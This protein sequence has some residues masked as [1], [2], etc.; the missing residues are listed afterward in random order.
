MTT[1]P[2]GA[3]PGDYRAGLL[4]ALRT[5]EQLRGR[6]EELDSGAHAPAEPIAVVGLSCRLPGGAQ[7]PESYWRMLSEGV[8]G[9]GE[10]PAERGDARALYDPDP[11]A[12][13]K[14]YT[15]RGAFLGR[16]DRFEPAVFG[17]SPREALG[18][19][20]QHRLA[21]EVAWEALERAGYAPDSLDGSNTGVYLGVSTTDYVRLRQAHGAAEDVDAY[22]LV[23]EPSFTAGRISYTLGLRGP[24][25]V[26]DTTCS[27]SLVAVHEACQAL[28]L[29]ECDMAL[30]GGVN[31][32]LA[33]YGFVL[34]SKFR[35][36][37]PDG[38]C[39][40]FDAAADGYARGEGAGVVTLKRLSDA[41]RDGDHISAVI[42]GSAVGHDGRSS[43]LTV[44]NPAAQQQV[45]NGALAQAHIAP[46]DVDYVEAHG[47]GTALGDP[48]ELR[49][50]QAA[51]A[52]HRPGGEPLL[53]GS[54]KTNI[55]H[56]ESAAGVAGL[57]KLI[58]ALEHRHI[59]PHLHF[60]T[61]N[62][63]VDWNRLRIRV[64]AEGQEWPERGRE[65]IGAI[66]SFGA[67]GTNAHAVLGSAPPPPADAAVRERGHRPYGLLLASARTPEA[68]RESAERHARALR[69][70]Q[71]SALG[72]VCW[73]TQVGRARQQY[74]LA[75]VGD[76]LDSL[77]EALE[78]YV[79]G[80]DDRRLA[81]TALP[82]HKHRKTAWLF[83]GQGA[84]YPGMCRDLLGE[85][86]FRAAFEE[87]ERIIDPLLGRPLRQVLWPEQ[88]GADRPIDD[89]RYT[90]PA[91]FAV[92]Y[93]LAR[94][95]MAWGLRPG[96]LLGHS[97]GEIAAACVAG[98]FGLADACR[99]VVARAALM[100]GLPAGGA[101]AAV[102]CS[103]A[104]ARAAIADRTDL[105]A[106]AAVNGPEET[107]LSGDADE[108]ASVLEL[109]AAGG[110]RGRRLPVSHAFHSPLLE[111]M[112]KAF[113]EVAEEIDYAAPTLPLIS[114]VTG[115][116]WGPEEIGPDYW[117][118][119]AASPVRFHDGL[120]AL[121]AQGHRTFLE[122]GPAPVL[123]GIG[124]RAID[125]AD[126]A[127]I[128]SLLPPASG[129][130]GRATVRR[131]LGLLRLRGAQPDWAAVHDGE[132]LRR[133]PLPTTPWRGESYWFGE[134]RPAAVAVQASPGRDVPGVGRRLNTAVPTYELDLGS[135]RW[136][137][138]ARTDEDGN[139]YIPL[140][141]M[142]GLTVAAA[143][144]AL[145][146]SW[147][148]VEE[149]DLLERLPLAREPQTL[150]ITVAATEDG[151][152][153]FAYRGLSRTEEE[154]GAPWRLHVRGVLRHHPAPAAGRPA[155]LGDL[156][157]GGYA[158]GFAYEP[159]VLSEAL[160]GAVT[161]AHRGAGGVLV[162]LDPVRGGDGTA[163]VGVM[164]AAVAALSWDAD[165]DRPGA[166]VAGFA[167]HVGLLIC[168]DPALVRYVRATAR[169]R[170]GLDGLPGEETVGAAEF[171]AEDG[172]HIGGV[173]ELRVL[174]AAATARRAAPWRRPDELLSR[175][176]W[177]PLALPSAPQ[178]T[179]SLRG[180]D[181]PAS[182]AG[183]SWLLLPDRG[184]VATRLAAE[185]RARGAHCS[186]ADGVGAEP[187]SVRALLARW[188]GQAPEEASL[189]V[190]VCTGLDAPSNEEADLDAIEEYRGRSELTAVVV[191][192]ELLASARPGQR[193]PVS[194]VTRGAQAAGPAAVVEPFGA[195]LWGLGR[196]LALEHPEFWGG[197]VDLG[198]ALGGDDESPWLLAALTDP[199]EDQQALRGAERYVAR[200]V[201]HELSADEQRARP[202]L[203][204]DAT[205]LVT[206][207]FGGIGQVLCRWLAAG[208]AG[209][210][211]L[212]GR[213]AL[214]D[215]ADWDEPALSPEVRARL[216]LVRDLEAMGVEVEIVVADVAD[217][218]TMRRVVEELTH[219]DRARRPLRGVVHAAGTSVPQFL[220]DIP[221]GDPR[222]YD[223]VWR[224]KVIGG[225]LLHQLTDGLELD[226]F[227]NFSSI[228]A[229]WGSQH[230][231]SY[232]AANAFLDAL[233]EHRHARGLPA[234]SVS[235]GPWDLASNLFDDD[236]LAFLTATG[237]R[238]LS[239]PQCL[240]LLGAL[241]A[242]K[243]PQAVVCAA[244]WG[245]YKPVMEARGER[246]L[247]RTVE[248]PEEESGPQ[249]SPL[250]DHL[251]SAAGA[252]ERQ[253]LLVPY[254][255]E[256]LG[257]V[258]GVAQDSLGPESD[259]LANGLDSLMV[260][261]VVKRCRRDL[262]VT[263][264]PNQ[265]FER[266]TL[267][268]WAGLLAD[269]T[270][271]STSADSGA[272]AID[273]T[274][275]SAWAD[276]ARIAE[277]VTLDPAIRPGSPP[278]S[279]YTEPRE[280][281]LTG[282]TGF[283]GAYLLDELLATT[284]A[285]VHCLVRCADAEQG[286]SRIRANYERY[287]P[288]RAE[289]A[290]RVAVVPGDL[291]L[292]LLGMDEAGFD[293]LADRL[294]AIYHNGALV[295]FSHTYEQ[296]RPANVAGTEEILR[297][298]CRGRLT[299]VSHVSTYGI[300]G[301]PA[302]GRTLITEDDPIA[303]AGKLVT[304][305]VQTK[306]A[307]ERLVE[308]ARERGIPVDVYRPGRVLGD[309][310]TGACLTT[311]FTTR[312]IKGCVQLGSAPALDLEIEMTPVD[313]VTRSL[314]RISRGEHAFGATYHLV[315]RHKL[316]FR[317]LV[318]AMVARGWRI[319]T[320]PTDAWWERLRA[321][322]A[323]QENALHAAM[324]V[325]EEFVVG[326]EEAIDY[327][328]L[329]TERALLGSGISCPP[330]DERLLD[331]YFDWMIR[332][333]YLPDPA[334]GPDPG[335]AAGP[336]PG[337]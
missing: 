87:C 293:A 32:M 2:T 144:D 281:L 100:A 327:D 21:L 286:L 244:D 179:G 106:V 24:S 196:V 235:W 47:T 88:S 65:R 33:P 22:Q 127:W 97:V 264:R 96:A 284:G 300:W 101:M 63:N 229:T 20:P 292:P 176:E 44:P 128:P 233:A 285:T 287:L 137:A 184:A 146:G 11:D 193:I 247:L 278:P 277:D 282:A 115:R 98:V 308:L 227:L 294:D 208:G 67:S 53:V 26:I 186:V 283:L 245:V 336:G 173:G 318:A 265:F 298:A 16:V 14:A 150:Q 38:R 206:G 271:G 299:P 31:L 76:S 319:G 91:L 52:R 161:A 85:P 335:P 103:E 134:N 246:P 113:R 220:R 158:D 167:S 201:P 232:S 223:A 130:D 254:L 36:L 200:L 133:V 202:V 50:L 280:V 238:P 86:A 204:A 192:Q 252:S 320:V 35:A 295:N 18:M 82:A 114:D 266:A 216:G 288:W 62:P 314:V 58:L 74:G 191:V 267:A 251:A 203:R 180:P 51:L 70:D 138:L 225:W 175:I 296:A 117:V 258:L 60:T 136:A 297:L 166:A 46:G 231:A 182:L 45:I 185:L 102:T 249:T 142:A 214:P 25:K 169:P 333:G 172:R 120:T 93:A 189:R 228:A 132:D 301:L 219:G 324:E 237:L 328:A 159:A 121:Y 187:E 250:L 323:E 119:H 69:R 80:E 309:S 79:R 77:A 66:S 269:A 7:D 236:V 188:R 260:M 8:D 3:A 330:L 105:L 199:G 322:F 310:R 211:V 230:L 6:I 40:T 10:F 181:A 99:L 141:A 112:L 190:V 241:L 19:D 224:P 49:A 272:P 118:R 207:A 178:G 64:T 306:W 302:D 170:T 290:G 263:L 107:V 104:T 111:P 153:E 168:P 165:R 110:V 164:D 125:D 28:R 129:T 157:L 29:G 55:G 94:M 197:A 276:P 226:F 95:W 37:S 4:D 217:P 325:V 84:Q 275:T 210:L 337:R 56:L 212:L 71:D 332:T 160:A 15:I 256:V 316:P 83:T 148:C 48:I 239:A 34:M 195:A 12:P 270:A 326:G 257:E 253:A 126:C 321:G 213:S 72:D 243:A 154:A 156:Q 303:G 135:D 248:L 313:Y 41:L 108:L 54:V 73:T 242:G 124:E 255:G 240:R 13:G 198:P 57:I 273:R 23:G 131:A 162:A 315:N 312:V 61:P 143:A 9:T 215:R 147:T 59:P 122:I 5:I 152:A 155:P 92:E 163:L 109:L 75:A 279:A 145:G 149:I 205:Y 90:Q 262:R 221:V 289:A 116:P 140:G 183:E 123:T 259:V 39:K 17:I 78:A 42:R 177:Q 261:E 234:L 331:T 311:H 27:S 171:F 151:R 329:R 307:A 274:V 218:V 334:A 43:G 304:G 268:E 174:P 89:T 317:D 68:L 222:E 139:R 30:A 194:L 291:A 305:Y 209:R 1:A 81:V